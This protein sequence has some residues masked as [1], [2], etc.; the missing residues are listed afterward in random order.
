MH[1]ERVL[2]ALVRR[3]HLSP[4]RV[5][6]SS[7]DRHGSP[8]R[9]PLQDLQLGA[10]ETN[11]TFSAMLLAA[12]DAHVPGPFFYFARRNERTPRVNFAQQTISSTLA[13]CPRNF[14]Q[15][16]PPP[17]SSAFF[18]SV[19]VCFFPPPPHYLKRCC[20]IPKN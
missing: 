8:A 15:N 5:S 18:L 2:A 16:S 19:C 10:I 20:T 17:P 11:S 13:F 7:S 14:A 1:S 4:F 9:F 3:N 12:D 6:R